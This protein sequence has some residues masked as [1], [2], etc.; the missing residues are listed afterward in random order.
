MSQWCIRPGG[1]FNP[2]DPSAIRTEPSPHSRMEAKMYGAGSELSIVSRSTMSTWISD[3]HFVDEIHK[4][5]RRVCKRWRKTCTRDLLYRRLPFLSWITKYDF[6]KLLSD[7]NAGMAVSLTAIPQT[8]GYAAVAGLPAQI[9]LYSAF[10]GPL[11]YIFFGTVREISVGPNSVLALMI[12]SYVSEGGVAYAV[13]LAFLTGV[14]QLIIGLLNLGFIV[15][16]ISAPVISGFCSAAALTAIATQMKGLLGLKFQGSNFLGVWRGVFENLSDINYYDAGLGFLTIFILL[17]MRKLNCMMN[18]EVFKGQSCLQNRWIS[19][20]LWFLS[21][22]R[23]A[24]VLIFSCLAAYLLEINGLNQLTLSGDI[25][26]GLPTFKLPPFQIERQVDDDEIQVLN[27]SDICAEIGAM[28]IALFPLVSILEQVAIAKTYSHGKSTDATQEIITLGIGNIAGSFVGAM[29][30]S[31]SFGRSAVQ[32]SS[33]VRTPMVNV[34]SSGV[35]LLALGLLMP[36]FYYLPKAVLAAVVI[37]S[38]MFLVEYEEIKPMWKSRRIELLPLVITFLSCLFVNMEFGIILGAGFHLL[39]LLH[40]GNKPKISVGEIQ[41]INVIKTSTPESTMLVLG[42][43][44]R[45]IPVQQRKSVRELVNTS[46]I[47]AK[48]IRLICDRSLHFPGIETFRSRI[49][50]VIHDEGCEKLIIIADLERVL[51]MDYTSLKVLKC[52]YADLQKREH[53]LIFDKANDVI[54]QHLTTAMDIPVSAF[55]QI[56]RHNSCF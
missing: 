54:Q 42:H 47:E 27:F 26:P 19:R 40:L 44:T 32:S 13:I 49:N 51:E 23:N 21:S 15:D 17:I 53:T 24:S 1:P 45:P 35:I 2:E 43:A 56:T 46:A 50:E 29:P 3:R 4:K 12:N 10:M 18:L 25:E 16:L 39:L 55:I 28:G 8:I 11:M 31:A 37:S 52:I 7:A 22:S 38:V 33:G 36:A 48:R 5:R 20:V 14:I 9:G 41:A 30:I 34:F 6:S